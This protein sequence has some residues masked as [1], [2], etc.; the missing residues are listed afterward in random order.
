MKAYVEI[1]V[2]IDWD[3]TP[4]QPMRPDCPG[5]H[6]ELWITEAIY[7]GLDIMQTLSPSALSTLKEQAIEHVIAMNDRGNEP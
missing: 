2:D 1:E 3:Y 4:P 5:S 7:N 6:A